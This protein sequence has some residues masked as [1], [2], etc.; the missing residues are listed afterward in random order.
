[1]LFLIPL[2][3]VIRPRLFY[4]N[5]FP[6]R[7]P[8]IGAVKYGRKMDGPTFDFRVCFSS[9]FQRLKPHSNSAGSSVQ[10]FQQKEHYVRAWY[11]AVVICSFPE[12]VWVGAPPVT[13]LGSSSSCAHKGPHTRSMTQVVSQ[14][15]RVLVLCVAALSLL[16]SSALVAPP[17]GTVLLEGPFGN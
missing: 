13:K 15:V 16:H 11:H 4:H 14:P 10:T 8:A 7:L 1:M 17:P 6:H 12:P 5:K 9:G 3:V 2:S